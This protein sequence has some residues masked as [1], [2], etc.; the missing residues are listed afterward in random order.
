MVQSFDA[1]CADPTVQKAPPE[2]TEALRK[3]LEQQRGFITTHCGS[4]AVPERV[5]KMDACIADIGHLAQTSTSAAAARR[6]AA[7]PKVAEVRADPEYQAAAAKLR[8]LLD[9]QQL[10]CENADNA[11]K[12]GSP[13]L[14]LWRTKCRQAEDRAAAANGE[15]HAILRRH[16][17]DPRDADALGL[18]P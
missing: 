10:H 1:L 7:S 2:A 15:R 9:E 12:D 6:S 3:T 16:G 14:G 4:I 13:N 18:K 5:A 17:I 8:T 11:E